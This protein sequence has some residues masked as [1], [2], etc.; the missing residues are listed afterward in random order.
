MLPKGQV[1]FRPAA[2]ALEFI[3]T[4]RMVID[5]TNNVMLVFVRGPLAR[6]HLH[7]GDLAGREYKHRQAELHCSIS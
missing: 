4:L 5:Q 3:Q 7:L 2:M 1:G 6:A